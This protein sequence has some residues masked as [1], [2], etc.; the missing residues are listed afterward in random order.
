MSGDSR[1]S[2]QSPTNNLIF[3]QTMSANIRKDSAFLDRVDIKQLV[4]NPCPQASYEILRSSINELIRCNVLESNEDG[5]STNAESP[6]P[7]DN[8][9]SKQSPQEEFLILPFAEMNVHLWNQPESS[10]RRL[11]QIAQDGDVWL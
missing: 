8:Q 4:P 9:D 7:K 11:W 3:S 5:A 10:S 6:M 1:H 2:I